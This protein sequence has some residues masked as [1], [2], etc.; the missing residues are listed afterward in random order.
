MKNEKYKEVDEC[1]SCSDPKEYHHNFEPTLVPK[2]C[3]CWE[4]WGKLEN[5]PMPCDGFTSNGNRHSS[6]VCE[7][8]EHD[9]DC[10]DD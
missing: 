9:K 1:K 10:H 5:I 6:L 2:N 7:I 3:V 4:S 8:C